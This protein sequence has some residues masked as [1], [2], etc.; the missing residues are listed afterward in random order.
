MNLN[1][2]I[3]NALVVLQKTYKNVNKMLEQCKAIS[4]DY[5]Y[6]TLDKTMRYKSDAD[7]NG[8]LVNSLIMIFQK[9]DAPDCTKNGWK[10]GPIYAVQVFL[11][12]VEEPDLSA[13]LCVSRFD[14]DDINGWNSDR[15]SP[16]D[17]WAFYNPTHKISSEFHFTDCGDYLISEPINQ[18]YRQQYEGLRK[19]VSKIFPLSDV[20][21][22]NL[23]QLIFKTFDELEY[24]VERK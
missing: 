8:W 19:T 10:N 21:V 20:T 7:P 13:Q 22:E 17:H 18:K 4:T 24:P 2:N 16:A 11:G 6:F 14:Y 3:K 1:E 23:G 12:S 15:F 5:G 9:T